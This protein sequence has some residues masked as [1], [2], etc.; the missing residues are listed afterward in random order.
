MQPTETN[1]DNDLAKGSVEEER[2]SADNHNSMAGQLEHRSENS[3][4]KQNDSDFPEPG[5]SPEHSGELGEASDPKQPIGDP[6]SPESRHPLEAPAR[7]DPQ[8][9][10]SDIDSPGN[11][12]NQGNGGRDSVE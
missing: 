2:S 8:Q 10:G 12:R 11:G 5:S 7:P 4:I 1:N 6:V 9:P 3:M